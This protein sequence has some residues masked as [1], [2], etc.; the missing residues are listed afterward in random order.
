METKSKT[1]IIWAVVLLV[2]CAIFKNILFSVVCV[3][4][5]IMFGVSVVIAKIIV[6]NIDIHIEALEKKVVRSEKAKIRLEVLNKSIFPTNKLY[7]KLNV[8]NVFFEDKDE[9]YINIPAF[10]KGKNSISF[11]LNCDYVGN[12]V[13]ETSELVIKDYLNVTKETVSL[14]KTIE[15]KVVPQDIQYVV[16]LENTYDES[17]EGDKQVLTIDSTELRGVREY[18]DGES[19]HRIHWKLSSK[20]DELMVKEFEMSLEANTLIMLDLV[21]GKFEHINNAI[22]V[23][24][25][26]LKGLIGRMPKGFTV[27]WYD[28][29]RDD[30]MY[31]DINNVEDID[32]LLDY[33]YETNLGHESGL[34]YY[35]YTIKNDV[36][37]MANAVLIT[38]K[39]N[40]QYGN[41]IG[42]YNDKV[43]LKCV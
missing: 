26:M 32:T 14:S 25:S 9:I 43:V 30:Y 37:G 4:L 23:M 38:D 21:K 19:L 17:D 40:K 7:V 8:H 27:N 1:Y 35:A 28:G 33:I 10:I 6:R 42:V 18:R 20:Y 36:V 13:L 11:E 22:E 41:V 24:C 15:L 31:Y 16:P 12:I 39:N 2:L 3:S 5:I 29:S 34:V